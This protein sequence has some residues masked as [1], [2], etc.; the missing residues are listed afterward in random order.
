VVGGWRLLHL[1]GASRE[2][3]RASMR[4]PWPTD[5]VAYF[6]S[7]T[8]WEFLLKLILAAA[9][10]PGRAVGVVVRAARGM[11]MT[12]LMRRRTGSE[13]DQ[14]ARQSPLST[15]PALDI[16]DG[17]G[18]AFRASQAIP[19]PSATEREPGI[20]FRCISSSDPYGLMVKKKS[21]KSDA[22]SSGWLAIM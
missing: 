5:G 6:C 10:A 13:A 20:V 8:G 12:S 17:H 16:A 1:I 3:P 22:A 7:A 19:S 14:G 11:R 21:S 9:R 15:N 18:R 4:I 2:A